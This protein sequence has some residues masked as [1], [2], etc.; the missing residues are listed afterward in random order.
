LRPEPNKYKEETMSLLSDGVYSSITFNGLG[1]F[2]FI[3]LLTYHQQLLKSISKRQRAKYARYGIVP[4]QV[5]RVLWDNGYLPGDDIPTS[6]MKVERLLDLLHDGSYQDKENFER[7]IWLY[8]KLVIEEVMPPYPR[9]R[10]KPERGL[11]NRY[12]RS[13]LRDMGES[14]FSN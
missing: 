2:R 6:G 11:I 5:L 10:K 4:H 8:Q 13:Q 14:F 9:V 1:D 12:T 3:D 7:A